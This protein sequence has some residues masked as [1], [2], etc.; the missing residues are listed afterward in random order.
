MLTAMLATIQ[1]LVRVR[2]L[3]LQILSPMKKALV[4]NLALEAIIFRVPTT[5]ALQIR[6]LIGAVFTEIASKHPQ[7]RVYQFVTSYVHRTAKCFAALVAA[8]RSINIVLILQVLHELSRVAEAIP[9]F[10][11]LMHGAQSTSSLPEKREL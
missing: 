9:A 2:V 10:D 7:S 6:L 3:V 11:A 1:M 5:M 8:E 4:A